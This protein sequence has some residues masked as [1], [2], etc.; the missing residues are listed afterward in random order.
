M[1]A[2]SS[3]SDSAPHSVIRPPTTH[4]AS[5]SV[6]S[7]TFCA[8]PAGDRKIP[9]PMVIPTTSATELQRPSVRGSRSEETDVV[10]MSRA[11]LAPPSPAPRTS[12]PSSFRRGT[13][14]GDVVCTFTS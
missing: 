7:G 5:M 3:A 1:A 6:G 2:A 8:M 9:E 4:N 14:V 13:E 10:A 11:S 12:V